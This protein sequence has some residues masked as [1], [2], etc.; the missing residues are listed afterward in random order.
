MSGRTRTGYEDVE[1]IK[2]PDGVIAVISRRRSTG[3]C[4]VA[5]FKSFE[6]DGVQEKTNF[7]GAKYF[8]AVRRVL[9]IAE[10]RLVELEADEAHR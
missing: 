1:E 10:K 9:D 4:S 3:A 6:R 8:P 5:L 7:L 2:D